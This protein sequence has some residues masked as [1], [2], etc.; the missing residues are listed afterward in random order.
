[1]TGTAPGGRL[2]LGSCAEPWIW[3]TGRA[4]GAA[5]YVESLRSGARVAEEVAAE[6]AV[7]AERRFEVRKECLKS[8]DG[9][10][11]DPDDRATA[12]GASVRLGPDG[13][14]G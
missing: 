5:D 10:I 8:A 12:S 2:T 7:L 13:A 6:L 1:V 4:A 14:I 11:E 3:A 9:L